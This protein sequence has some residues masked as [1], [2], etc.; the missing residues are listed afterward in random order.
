MDAVRKCPPEATPDD[1]Y[2]D[3]RRC[4]YVVDRGSRDF[5]IREMFVKRGDPPPKAESSPHC[6]AIAT[7]AGC[8]AHGGVLVN[9]GDYAS[10]IQIVKGRGGNGMAGE[11]FLCMGSSS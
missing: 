6:F 10:R 7:V 8:N 5:L 11:L 3:R 1:P 2:Y 9:L 4:A